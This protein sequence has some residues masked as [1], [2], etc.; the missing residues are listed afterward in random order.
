MAPS[1]SMA[2]DFGAGDGA[3]I[4]DENTLAITG[5]AEQSEFLLFDLS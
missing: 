2:G 4:D 5:K 3:A 1:A